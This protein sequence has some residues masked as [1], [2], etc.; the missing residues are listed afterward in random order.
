MATR[1][2]TALSEAYALTLISYPLDCKSEVIEA[3]QKAT[4][5]SNELSLEGAKALVEGNLPAAVDYYDTEGARDVARALLEQAGAVVSALPSHPSR[6]DWYDLQGRLLNLVH[7]FQ[8]IDQRLF[9]FQD[10]PE[11]LQ[12]AGTVLHDATEALDRLHNDYDGWHVRVVASATEELEPRSKAIHTNVEEQRS[13][14]INVVSTV[15][16]LKFSEEAGEL[17]GPLELIEAELQRIT[18]AL[19]QAG[20][21]LERAPEE[22]RP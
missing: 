15:Q 14:L 19:A 9:D 16:C 11:E 13:R 20:T 18:D 6:S 7:H 10:V 12:P 21:R 5:C 17:A 8:L 3:L 2:H 4:E 1:K 22:A